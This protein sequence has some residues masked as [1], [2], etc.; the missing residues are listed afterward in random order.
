M[1]KRKKKIKSRRNFSRSD[2]F[3]KKEEKE[4]WIK[5]MLIRVVFPD[6]KKR[7]VYI[8]ALVD[9]LENEPNLEIKDE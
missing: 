8:Q 6:P 2:F 5:D 1:N 7:E 3:P 9:G 4:V